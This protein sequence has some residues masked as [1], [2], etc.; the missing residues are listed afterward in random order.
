MWES[1]LETAEAEFKRGVDF[2]LKSQQLIQVEDDAVIFQPIIKP[3]YKK[4]SAKSQ[5]KQLKKK[6]KREEEALKKKQE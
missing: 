4:P 3:F 6:K 1:F 2:K 5:K